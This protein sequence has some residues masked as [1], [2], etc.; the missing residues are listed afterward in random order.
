MNNRKRGLLRKEDNQQDLQGNMKIHWGPEGTGTGD[1]NVTEANG[2]A[3][4][5]I[6]YCH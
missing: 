4:N 6:N 5:G 1:V 2:N 3:N